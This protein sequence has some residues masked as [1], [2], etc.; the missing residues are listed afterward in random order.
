VTGCP[1]ATAVEP[2]AGAAGAEGLL[3]GAIPAGTPLGSSPPRGGLGGRR[4][5][6]QPL[7]APSAGHPRFFNQ[8][9]TGLDVI[10]LAG[11]WLTS[12]A[13]TNM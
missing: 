6:S 7:S 12:A 13:N 8:L 9:S 1:R 5:R 4:G 10:G 2:G 11:E 3:P